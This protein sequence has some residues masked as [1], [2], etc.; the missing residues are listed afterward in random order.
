MIMVM[1]IGFSL[2]SALGGVLFIDEAY[3]LVAEKGDD[4]YGTEALQVLLKLS[5]GDFADVAGLIAEMNLRRF[6]LLRCGA[7]R[8]ERRK[9]S[10]D[11]AQA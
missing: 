11:T 6:A 1:F 8:I 3:S 2:G 4:P 10:Q 7:A 9:R 5:L